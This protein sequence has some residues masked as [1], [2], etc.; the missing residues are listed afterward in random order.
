[1]THRERVQ[2]ALNHEEPD[3]IPIDLGGSCVTSI[4]ASSYQ[5]LRTYLGLPRVPSN[6]SDVVEQVVFVDDDVLD[7]LDADVIPL[8]ANAPAIYQPEFRLHPD[9]SESFV[10]EFGAT[11]RKPTGGFYFD[12]CEFPLPEPSLESLADMPWPDPADPARY[13]G[14]RERALQ[15]RA[16]S[17]RAIFGTAPCG[18]DLFNQLLRVR[19]MVPGLTDLLLNEEFAEA[20]LDRYMHTILRAQGLFLDAVGDLL[21]VH[22]TA[23]DLTGQNGPFIS[24]QLYRRLIKP[25]WAKIISLIKSK[26][27]AKIFYHGC[28]AM[29]EFLPDLIEIGVDIINPVQVSAAGMDTAALKKDFGKHLAFWGGGCDTQRILPFGTPAEVQAEV[30]RRIANLAPGGGF[31]F[32]P[33]HNIQPHVPAENIVTM[34]DTA[35]NVGAYPISRLGCQSGPVR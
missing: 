15:L 30:Q 11:L 17:D 22:F 23:D 32:N 28:G 24:P 9:G 12:W 27:E 13:A 18:H 16:A 1:V 8:W 31:V 34:F 6:M 26:T 2:I 3:R 35:R 4:A 33:V 25:R 19:G 7:I 20:F 14:L 29:R 5:E 21:D 10:D